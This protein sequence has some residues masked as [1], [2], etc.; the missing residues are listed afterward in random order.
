MP[1]SGR[2][3]LK[4]YVNLDGK[5]YCVST[6]G[7]TIEH[8]GGTWFET[9]VFASEDLKITDYAER[10]CDRYK[11]EAEAQAGH[12]KTVLLLEDGKI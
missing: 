2:L 3:N 6:V 7:L 4:A 5:Q 8:Y 11:T 12:A 1:D 10:F 9:M